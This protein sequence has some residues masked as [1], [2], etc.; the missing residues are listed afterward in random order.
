MLFKTPV[1]TGLIFASIFF[2]I[3]IIFKPLLC[4]PLALAGLIIGLIGWYLIDRVRQKSK[5]TIEIRDEL[6]E[7]ISLFSEYLDTMPVENVE[8][9]SKLKQKWNDANSL[10]SKHG[11]GP[12]HDTHYDVKDGN[13][14]FIKTDIE[15]E[16]RVFHRRK[17]EPEFQ[18]WSSFMAMMKNRS[19][20][21]YYRWGVN[22]LGIE[23]HRFAK[24][25]YTLVK[26]WND[27]YYK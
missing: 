11:Y 24:D 20:S 10:V 23:I 2:V 5:V 14:D 6:N 21:C 17:N 27:G 3:G 12:G 15:Q 13:K 22:K 8:M 1:Q 16:I 26:A 7:T 9:E 25:R 19:N 18:G 4:V